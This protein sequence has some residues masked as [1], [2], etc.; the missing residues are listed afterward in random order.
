MK[1]L[2]EIDENCYNDCRTMAILSAEQ[3]EPRLGYIYEKIADGIVVEECEPENCVDRDMVLSHIHAWRND[4]LVRMT[5][6]L[7]YLEKRIK[8]LPI[9]YPNNTDLIKANNQ[10]KKQIEMLKLDRDIKENMEEV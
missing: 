4:E 9:S 10:L 3:G 1:V 2:V 7:Y 8:D 6:P 5:N